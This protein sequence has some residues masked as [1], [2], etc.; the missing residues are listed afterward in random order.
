MMGKSSGPSQFTIMVTPMLS[1][2]VRNDGEANVVH[3]N[4]YRWGSQSGPAQAMTVKMC[5]WVSAHHNN[6]EVESTQENENEGVYNC[7]KLAFSDILQP[8]RPWLL[9]TLGLPK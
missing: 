2:S 5:G 3:L 7:Q 1:I 4:S 6:Q 8:T 9:K